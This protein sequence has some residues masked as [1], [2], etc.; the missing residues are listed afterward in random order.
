MVPCPNAAAKT[1]L[2]TVDIIVSKDPEVR[3]RSLANLCSN[4]DK[5]TLLR[6]CE[7]LDTFR[8]S[9][10]NLYEKVRSCFFLYAIHRYHL[11][12][13]L[14]PTGEIP[15][16]GYQYLQQRNFQKAIDAFLLIHTPQP[17]Q[18]ISSALAKAYYHLGFQTLADQVRLSVKHY[19]GNLWMY[20]VDLA[21][22]HPKKVILPPNKVL[23]EQTPV[24]MDLR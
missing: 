4:L 10:S 6:E 20:Q 21:N 9:S 22:E 11:V 3:N 14:P 8:R 19:P 23:Q 7:S 15:F 12:S 5:A 16:E 24:R 17:S 2:S 13:H 1:S 18:A